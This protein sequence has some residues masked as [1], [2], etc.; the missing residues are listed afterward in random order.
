MATARVAALG[1]GAALISAP[2]NN[3]VFDIDRN[4]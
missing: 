4:P 2:R 1:A 3:F